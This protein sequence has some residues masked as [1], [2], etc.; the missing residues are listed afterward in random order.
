MSNTFPNAI[1]S[2]Y[3]V[4][5]CENDPEAGNGRHHYQIIGHNPDGEKDFEAQIKFQKG[6]LPDVGH[7]GILSSQLLAILIDH[8]QQYQTGP[9][10]S[11]ETAI[12]ITHLQEAENWIARRANER[13]GRG[14]LGKHAK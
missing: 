8:L 10:A 3:G 11:R 2:W 4:F 9:Y 1:S 5:A 14:V 7:N 12:A 6:P 13:A